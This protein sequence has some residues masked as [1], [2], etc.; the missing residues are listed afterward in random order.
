MKPEERGGS[1]DRIL[2][3]IQGMRIVTLRRFMMLYLASYGL[4]PVWVDIHAE[5]QRRM[6]SYPGV[7]CIQEYLK[8]SERTARDYQTAYSLIS[9]IQKLNRVVGLTVL[10]MSRKVRSA[11]S[12]T[13]P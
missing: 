7:R 4:L 5:H 13:P 10:E 9:E 8:C 2:E 11:I 12:G 1:V 3:R 6:R